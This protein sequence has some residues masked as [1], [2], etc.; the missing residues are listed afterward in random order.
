MERRSPTTFPLL[1]HRTN[2]TVQIIKRLDPLRSTDAICGDSSPCSVRGNSHSNCYGKPEL[3]FL[4]YLET[5]VRFLIALPILIA[6]ELL[7]HQR[8]GSPLPGIGY[9][10]FSCSSLHRVLKI[11]NN[12]QTTKVCQQ[13]LAAALRVFPF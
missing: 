10:R 8:F 2:I 12:L 11:P 9:I 4:R 5:H 3:V 7:V 1:A 13:R 6:A